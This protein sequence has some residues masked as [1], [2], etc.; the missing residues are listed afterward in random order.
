MHGVTMKFIEVVE[1]YIRVITSRHK[2]NS[3]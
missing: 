3:Q 1:V 2:D